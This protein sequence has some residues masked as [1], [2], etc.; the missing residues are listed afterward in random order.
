MSFI[1]LVAMGREVSDGDMAAGG[2]AEP[3]QREAQ[4][5]IPSPVL[6]SP[7]T[8]DEPFLISEPPFPRLTGGGDAA[9]SL[10]RTEGVCTE[11]VPTKW[12]PGTVVVRLVDS[13]CP[14]LA[15]VPQTPGPL[16]LPRPLLEKRFWTESA[17]EGGGLLPQ[18]REAVQPLFWEPTEPIGK[19]FL[20]PEGK[21][22]T[23]QRQ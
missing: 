5:Q 17:Q 7:L 16:P 20:F 1:S 10:G 9:P 18:L 4:V 19:A 15:L 8:C 21:A 3:G 12:S 13:G 22:D 23:S 11:M 6:P 14:G 2:E